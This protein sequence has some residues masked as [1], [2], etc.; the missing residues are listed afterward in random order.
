MQRRG[1][2][3]LLPLLALLLQSRRRTNSVTSLVFRAAPRIETHRGPTQRKCY[4]NRME[5]EMSPGQG[6]ENEAKYAPTIMSS[7]SIFRIP[8]TAGA[9][10]KQRNPS[11]GD[12]EN[13]EGC[14]PATA[15]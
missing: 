6:S 5:M 9:S 12:E 3:S 13:G 8:R 2:P 4:G 1:A 15:H 11:G 10:T 14:E 7:S